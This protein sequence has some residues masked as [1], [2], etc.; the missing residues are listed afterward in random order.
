[1]AAFEKEAGAEMVAKA[2]AAREAGAAGIVVFSHSGLS[3]EDYLVARALRDGVFGAAAEPPAMSWKDELP[4]ATGAAVVTVYVG[5]EPKY[6]VRVVQDVPRRHAYLL[7]KEIS[8]RLETRVLI[9]AADVFRYRV[10]AGAYA[11]RPA[12]ADLRKRR[13]EL[14]Y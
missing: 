5:G 8:S 9:K 7:A 1:M 14:G 4:L 2:R 6:A 11:E 12:A 3:K 13:S 10:Y